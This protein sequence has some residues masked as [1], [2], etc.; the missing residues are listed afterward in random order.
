MRDNAALL[1]AVCA[2]ILVF[3]PL[4]VYSIGQFARDVL[5]LWSK[6]PFIKTM[7]SALVGADITVDVTSTS[8]VTLGLAHPFL[9]AVT[10]GFLIATGT[11]AIT[12]EIDRGTADLLLTLPVSRGGVW[13][14]AT[15]ALLAGLGVIGM[16]PWLGIAMG[17]RLFP[18]A[19]AVE[20]R[21]LWVAVVNFMALLAAILGIT[22]LASACTS[23]RGV[24]VAIAIAVVLA[25]FLLNFVVALAP[26]LEG[27]APLGLLHYY[28]PLEAVRRG[29]LATRDVM[30]LC[31]IAAVTWSV[32]LWR[33]ARR[34]IPA[35]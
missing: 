6:F 2:A 32:G 23:R 21:L 17:A 24:A 28:R 33:F 19:D 10:W 26:P 15:A 34:D 5:P 31:G 3:E 7:I 29:E 1:A 18:M 30:V 27:L 12:G 22:L 8:L 35:A 25:S 13:M 11:R 16:L 9:F 4:L 14:S 20:P